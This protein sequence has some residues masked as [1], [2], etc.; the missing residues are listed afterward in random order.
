MSGLALEDVSLGPLGGVRLALGSGEVGW[1]QGAT[2]S[3]KTLLLYLAAGLALPEEGRVILNGSA[4]EPDR[5]AMLFQN[6]DYQLLA[7]S[8][9]AD[10]GMN[11]RSPEDAEATLELAGCRS[12]RDRAPESLTP[13]QRRRVALAGVLAAAPD[14]ALLDLPF[15]GLGREEAERLWRSC[16][17]RLV[18]AGATVLVTGEPVGEAANDAIWEVEQWLRATPQST[19]TNSP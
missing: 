5:V 16:R 3:G 2:G 15:A 17:Q 12:F 18:N 6:P 1:A 11:A 4:P 7:P 8:V 13:G 19:S 9:E 14:L 10:V